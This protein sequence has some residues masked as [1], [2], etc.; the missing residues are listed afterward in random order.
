MKGLDWIRWLAVD[1]SPLQVPGLL[2]GAIAD[3]IDRRLL[4]LI[5]ASGAA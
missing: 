2:G 5:T 1:T 4:L 3:A